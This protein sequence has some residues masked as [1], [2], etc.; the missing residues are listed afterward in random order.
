MTRLYMQ[1]KKERA[2]SGGLGEPKKGGTFNTPN[3][4]ETSKGE[5]SWTR[6]AHAR[7]VYGD[8]SP[9][10]SQTGDYRHASSRS[11]I[12]RTDGFGGRPG[13][14]PQWCKRKR[15]SGVRR[16]VGRSWRDCRVPSPAG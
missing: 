5:A 11:S 1:P 8:A 16:T 10:R 9:Y 7:S 15:I 12:A 6:P 2:R 4:C 3:G 13:V 14:K